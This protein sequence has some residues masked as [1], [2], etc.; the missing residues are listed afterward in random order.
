MLFVVLFFIL[1]SSIAIFFLRRDKQTRLMLGLCVSFVCMFIGIII[2]LSKTGGL[3]TG[4]KF[5]LF[6]DLR[7]QRRLSY[8]IF[9]LRKLGYMIA[10]GRTL[11]PGFLL[12]LAFDYSMIPWILRSKSRHILIMVLPCMT[13]ILYYPSLFLGLAKWGKWLQFLAI[14][15]T[16]LWI[17][18]Y[19]MAALWLLLYEYKS[20]TIPYCKRQFRYIMVFLISMGVMYCFYFRQDP[21]QVYQMYSAE[22]MRYGGLL[23]STSARG[24]VSRWMVLSVLTTLFG[25]MGFLSLKSYSVMEHE[26]TRGDVI[27]QK[28]MDMASKGLSV[29]VHGMKNQLLSNRVIQERLGE[30]LQ[31][32]DSD[33][34]KLLEYACMLETINQNMISRMEELY[35]SIKSNYMTLVPTETSEVV[36]R[37]LERFH[38]KY[39]DAAVETVIEARTLILADAVHLSEALYN[40]AING[41]E[42]ILESGRQEKSLS[43]KVQ[44]ERLYVT[45]EIRD[46]GKGMS[47]QVQKKIFDPFYTSKN[48]NN[49]WGLGLYYVRQI[50]KNHFGMLK[51]ESTEGEGTTFFVAIPKCNSQAE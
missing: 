12:M 30:E 10:M 40:L 39:P 44:H 23:Y 26:E 4:Q 48:T 27:I 22:Y 9:P 29:F 6:F 50:V 42:S 34:E 35:K 5:F 17:A 47:R 8:M 46:N 37:V 13:L 32:E 41:Y 21:I 51:L 49:N 25:I 18:C 15:F 43:I 14:N 2:Y 28:K 16:I 3:Q 24:A 1:S 33:K 31:K 36:R 11:F 7:V 38:E 20:I 45:F 19:L